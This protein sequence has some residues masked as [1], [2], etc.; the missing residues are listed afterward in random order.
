VGEETSPLDWPSTTGIIR[1]FGLMVNYN[2]HSAPELMQRG[3]L[4]HAACHLLATGDADL[5]WEA[6]HPECQPFVEA[7]RRFLREHTF[8]LMECERE[9]RSET[10]R[11]ISHPDQIGLLDG[12][13]PVDLEIKS[14]ALPRWVQLQTAGQ[15]LCMGAP[16]MRRFALHLK[17]DGTYALEPHEDWRDLDRFRAMVDTY[18]T[19]REF[20]PFQLG[21]IPS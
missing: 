2:P 16:H 14:G 17:G 10:Y 6:R 9:Y 12:K 19:Q 21:A 4:V 13:R 3:R 5:A 15:V 8:R 1:H 7:Y 20:S 18:W 11:F